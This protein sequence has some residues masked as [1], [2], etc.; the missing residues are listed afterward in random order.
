MELTKNS[1]Q[2]NEKPKAATSSPAVAVPFIDLPLQFANLKAEIDQALAPIFTSAGFIMGPSVKEFEAAFAEF[3]G[4]E[5]CVTVHTGT[6]AL[7]LALLGLDIGP[8]DEIITA[9]NS[10]VATAEAIEF[11]GARTRLVDVDPETYNLDPRKIEAA[12]TSDTKAIIP[13]HLYGQA[14]DMKPIMEV[15]KKHNLKVI[16]D[17]CQAHGTT[18]EGVRVGTTGDIACFS[19]Y[20]GKNLGAAGEGGA[21]VTNDAALANRIRLLRDHGS[22]KKYEHEIVGHNFRL[23]TVQ[24]AILK[25]KLPHLDKWNKL[26]QSH[27]RFYREHLTDLKGLTLRPESKYGEHIYHLFVIELEERH[28][29]QEHLQSKGIQ[30]GIHYPIPI[31][32]QK[33]F[34]HLGY[35]TGDFP[36]SENACG[37]VLSLPM[38][39][40]LSTAQLEL[41]VS[42]VREYFA[43]LN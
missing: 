3:I 31:H 13:V 26:R 4:A 28:R 20:P 30:S 37:K 15:A 14:A 29:L 22:Q 21:I 10:F 43:K 27:A 1:I 12:I 9:A 5:H 32:L 24:A 18:Y 23:D 6:A 17:A 25:I 2:T 38:Y 41:V 42:A 33:G 39:P 35:K 8:G 36:V 16:E 7:H 40:E 11:A 19:F 34:A